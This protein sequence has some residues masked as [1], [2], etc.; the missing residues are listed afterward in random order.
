MGEANNGWIDTWADC[1][2]Y[3]LYLTFPNYLLPTPFLPYLSISL[4]ALILKCRPHSK[5]S[6][7]GPPLKRVK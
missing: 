3:L 4:I 7:R 2:S 1:I 5:Q 6:K